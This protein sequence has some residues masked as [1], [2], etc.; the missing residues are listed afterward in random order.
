[1]NT[2]K[3]AGWRSDNPLKCETWKAPI[4]KEQSLWSLED[5]EEYAS[6]A[7]AQGHIGL[8]ALLRTYMCFGQRLG[9]MRRMKHGVHYRDGVFA[10]RQQ[11]T[12]ITCDN[13]VPNSVANYIDSIR[14]SGSD[15]LF[16]HPA[17]GTGYTESQLN[18][19]FTSVRRAI[20]GPGKKWLVMKSLRHSFVALQV[21]AKAHPFDIAESTGHKHETLFKI[22]ERYSLRKGEGARRAARATNRLRGGTDQDFSKAESAAP[23]VKHE[24]RPAASYR[25]GV[26]RSRLRAALKHYFPE[27]N[28]DVMLQELTPEEASRWQV[29]MGLSSDA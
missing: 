14:V 3:L 4:P 25:G 19:A 1:M 12:G 29:L 13:D 8:A 20:H 11:K 27:K 15:Y 28:V 2:A 18:A 17:T 23:L 10:V 21:A 5:L 9:D 26:K 24:G 22:M 6:E 7:E 16:N